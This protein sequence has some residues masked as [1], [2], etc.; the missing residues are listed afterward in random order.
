MSGVQDQLL[1]TLVKAANALRG[2]GIPFALT[3]GCAVY[4][5]GGP[6]TEH[7]VDILVREED[8][9]PAVS[10]LVAAG[11]RAADP[12][13]DWLLKVYDGD[14]L[15]D[16]LFRPNELPV[17]DETLA[18]A[19]DLAVGS[20]TLPVMPAT[21]VMVSKLLVLDGHRCDFSELLPFARALREQ[22]DWSR[23]V[24][25]TAHSPY[26]EAFLVLVERLDIR[27]AP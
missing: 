16:L 9:K 25:A 3:G 19:E 23:V 15:V 20:V 8:A 5:R 22:I 10:A 4:A 6:A 17:T 26:A 7:D 14:S 21:E 18:R 11:M 1:R 2:Q 27:S 12:P 24:E 13:E